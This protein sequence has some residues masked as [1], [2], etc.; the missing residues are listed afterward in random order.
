MKREQQINSR[1]DVLASVG[2]SLREWAPS[3]DE[4]RGALDRV[5][6]GLRWKAKQVP[7]EAVRSVNLGLA[8]SE[9]L[10]VEGP[11]TRWNRRSTVRAFAAAAMVIVAVGGAMVWPR[12]A[13]VY[14]AGAD[15]LQ[16]TLA[17]DS[18]VEMRAHA[19]MTVDRASD[20]IQ[21]DLKTG[22]IIVTAAKQRDGHLY[23]RTSDMTVAVE[24]TAFLANAGQQGSRVGVIEG[25]VR[26]REGSVETLL[27]PG[28]Q[29]ATSPVLAARPVRDDILWSRNADVHRAVIDSFMK[30]VA[31]TTVPLTPL[32]RQADVIGAQT[33]GAKAAALEFEEA[34]IRPCDPNNL[35]AAV[36]GGRGGGGANAVYMTPGRFYA[37]CMTP[38]T[39]IRTAYGYLSVAQEVE[40]GRLVNPEAP[41]RMPGL[42]A[43]SVATFLAEDGQ[44]VRGGPDWV[45]T[46]AYTIEAVARVGDG[47]DVCAPLSIGGRTMPPIPNGP[48]Q[49]ANAVSMSGPMLR[50]LLERR[51]GLKAHIVT[52]QAQAF[53][54]GV[55]AGGFKMKEGTCT[56]DPSAPPQGPAPAAPGTRP[57]SETEFARLLMEM[58]RRNL[59]AARRGDATTGSTG[60]YSCGI[61]G[62]GMADNGPNRIFVGGGA[63]VPGLVQMLEGILGA[64]VTDR[65]GIPGTS[66]FNYALEFVPDERTRR[67]PFG[68]ISDAPLQIA[69]DPSSVQPAPNLFTALERQLGLR[70]E[71]AQVP[72]DYIVIDA[73]K[74]LEPN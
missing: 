60:K 68:A 15:G 63:R 20:G 37:L 17:D 48:C 1:E 65:T 43:G 4:E 58:V 52:E 13:R 36:P 24:G 21:I 12:G 42:A 67:N 33:P 8:L 2:D 30:G 49:S 11:A 18:S 62:L 53:Y 74:R 6:T 5:W 69:A 46:E 40:L 10:R 72:R 38:A 57:T 66:G 27:R 54:L 14:A 56:P 3:R 47:Q 29:L 32:A 35:P 73:I 31:Q 50:A 34:S 61:G 25:E 22:D 7:A 45:R 41:G 19:E 71:P 59:D 70:L 28:E 16:V 51:F 9:R 23:V 26:V 55:A 64:R 44:R 39:M